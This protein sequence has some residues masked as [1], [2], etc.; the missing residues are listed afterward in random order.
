M[1]PENEILKTIDCTPTWEALLPAMLDIV[2]QRTDTGSPF[3]TDTEGL[4]SEFGRM[5]RAADKWNAHCKERANPS[6]PIPVKSR[7]KFIS[8]DHAFFDDERELY[9]V[10]VGLDDKDRTLYA[11][12]YGQTEVKAIERADVIAIALNQFFETQQI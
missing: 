8:G 1:T 11:A 7:K 10:H 6:T 2:K 4:I 9:Y 3:P 12:I 5:A